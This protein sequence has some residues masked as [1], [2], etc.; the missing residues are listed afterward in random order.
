MADFIPNWNAG[1]W[2]D[3]GP[4][5]GGWDPKSA[6]S[7]TSTPA[8]GSRPAP[9][10]GDATFFNNQKYDV[11]NYQYPSDL[12]G[13]LDQYGNNYVVFYINVAVDSKVL[14]DPNTEVVEDIVPRDAGDL[15]GQAQSDPQTAK[16]V[17][18]V[19]GGLGGFGAGKVISKALGAGKNTSNVIAG[20]SAVGGGAAIATSG[21][22]FTGQKKRL[23]TAIA[24]HVPFQLQTRYGVNY[25]EEDTG[26]MNL[27]LVG[28]SGTSSLVKSL[29]KGEALPDNLG[30][31]V[32]AFVE[33]KL[34]STPGIGAGL[35][36]LTGHA[37]NPRKEQIFKSVDFRTFQFAYEFFPRDAQEAEY[38]MNIIN[39][40]KYHMHPEFKDANNFL[41]IYPSEFDI[42][43]YHG[44]T[45]NLFINKHTSCVL[46]EM[47]VNYSPQGQ[48]TTF[49][50]GMPTQINVIMTFKELALLTKDKIKKGL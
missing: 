19:A 38:V 25:E 50:N 47:T 48:F 40:F 43:Y 26:L 36:K 35:S 49:E 22:N 7:S 2:A 12:M 29:M 15:V 30:A 23:K 10:F 46:T 14:S 41:Y 34:Y 17:S 28:A 3:N 16:I 5:T 11:S 6:T 20:A 21:T 9:K 4:G 32:G 31:N 13:S 45:E 37:P 24:L 42:F 39:Q 1:G 44:A 27:A 18:T 33:S 8:E